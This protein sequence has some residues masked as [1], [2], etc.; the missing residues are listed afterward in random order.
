MSKKSNISI[1]KIKE[2]HRSLVNLTNKQRIERIIR[3][4]NKEETEKAENNSRE[5]NKL[6][7]VSN[8]TKAGYFDVLIYKKKRMSFGI[9][10]LL[11]DYLNQEHR[12]FTNNSND[13]ICFFYTEDIIFGLASGGGFSIL[14]PYSDDEFPFHVAKKIFS[15]DFSQ[16]EARKITGITYSEMSQYRGKGHRFSRRESFGKIW[17]KLIGK[18]RPNILDDFPD[19]AEIID[20]NRKNNAEIK[21]SI[22]FKKTLTEET[23]INV[24]NA[25]RKIGLEA[26]TEEEKIKFSFLDTVR[27]ISDKTKQEGLFNKLI[28]DLRQICESEEWDKAE[29]FDFCHPSEPF[30]FFSGE[31]FKIG[32]LV[33]SEAEEPTAKEI[34]QFI[35]EKDVLDVSNFDNFKRDIEIKDLEFKDR[36]TERP[37]SA[38]LIKYFHG[39]IQLGNKTYFLVDGK[40]YEVHENFLENLK[41]DFVQEIF[42]DN[43]KIYIQSI[44]LIGWT[45]N[46]NSKGQRVYLED[47]FNTEQAKQ[48]D[49]YLGDKIFLKVERGEIELFDL[50]YV[51]DEYL[52]I[53]QAKNGFGGSVRD[54]CSQIQ[55]SAETIERDLIS[56]KSALKEFYEKWKDFDGNDLSEEEFL[57]LF[58]KKR[59]YVLACSVSDFSREVFENNDLYSHIAKFETLELSHYFSGNKWEFNIQNI[60]K[61]DD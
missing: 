53:I 49:F 5:A 42:D 30:M 3:I 33:V 13:L 4:Y 57:N 26:L 28:D 38:A 60:N 47:F 58:E 15:G 44:P 55:M 9:S 16:Q 34:L 22:V 51:T 23:L 25:L 8:D 56:G 59:K 21:S 46:T 54:A 41:R 48:N 19:L 11:E 7:K 6:V 2:D 1:W 50:L 36:S 24:L 12:P 35:K 18:I 10:L 43:D 45:K 17:K 39:E 61:V 52:Y 14:M 31:D 27:L 37:L 40:W 29:N 32:D 20:V